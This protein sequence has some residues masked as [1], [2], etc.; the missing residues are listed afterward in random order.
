MLANRQTLGMS[1][2]DTSASCSPTRPTAHKQPWAHS[3]LSQSDHR[4]AVIPTLSCHIRDLTHATDLSP[5]YP[6]SVMHQKPRFLLGGVSA[7]APAS[8]QHRLQRGSM[9]RGGG[10]GSTALRSRASPTACR[11]PAPCRSGQGVELHPLITGKP[12][13]CHRADEISGGGGGGHEP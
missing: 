3:P 10:A 11:F 8:R 1:H 4:P 5:T 9:W 13:I 7:T 6:N 12:H 2:S